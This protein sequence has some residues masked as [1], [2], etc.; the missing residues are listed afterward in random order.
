VIH[1]LVCDDYKPIAQLIKVVLNNMGMEVSTADNGQEAL[2]LVLDLRPGL[3]ISDID[4]PGM[5]GIELFTALQKDTTGLA[6]TPFIL[7]SSIDRR[8]AS[9]EAG[10]RHFLSKPFSIDEVRQA[11]RQALAD[12]SMPEGS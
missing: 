8:K 10:C 2:G 4:M 3:I 1:A 12:E 5:S 11:V 7:M 9:R 6:L